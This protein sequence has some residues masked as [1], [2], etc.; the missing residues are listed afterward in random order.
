MSF[1]AWQSFLPILCALFHSPDCVDQ[2]SLVACGVAQHQPVLSKWWPSLC[3][4]LCL[5][6]ADGPAPRASPPCHANPVKAQ[7]LQLVPLAGSVVGQPG[8]SQ[9]CRSRLFLVSWICLTSF[10]YYA[11]SM[12]WLLFSSLF[13]LA[14]ALSALAWNLSFRRGTTRLAFQ[15]LRSAA[16]LTLV[17]GVMIF[18]LYAQETLSQINLPIKIYLWTEDCK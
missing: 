2:L 5:A 14:L 11:L 12:H 16:V 4:P 3:Q 7:A 17:L 13:S 8:R 6:C 9:R 1:Q 10:S 18:L 15:R